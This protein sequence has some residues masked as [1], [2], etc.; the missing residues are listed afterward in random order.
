M[1]RMNRHNTHTTYMT[2]L[3]KCP[4][5]GSHDTARSRRKLFE[6]LLFRLK[7]YRCGSCQHRFFSRVTTD[8]I[9]H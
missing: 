1:T 8:H 6:R 5:C 9:H 2:L 3:R 4:R 7:P